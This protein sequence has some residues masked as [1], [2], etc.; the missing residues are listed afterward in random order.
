MSDGFF[1]EL[2]RRNVIRMAGLYLAAG[3]VAIEVAGTVLPML[4]A[5]EWIG[6][7]VL[8]LIAI[9]FVP[10]LVFAWVFEITPDG[11]KR[12]NEIE[13]HTSIMPQT[14]KRMD[15]AI[16]AV[17]LVG[18]VY[19]AFDKFVLA[20][21]REAAVV[22]S[23]VES[24]AKTRP[25]AASAIQTAIPAKSIAVLPLLND[26]GDKEQQYFADGLSENLINALS[27]FD[28]L[29]VIGRNSAFQFREHQE[30]SVAIGRKLGVA[31]LLEG[32]V[33]RQ[34][35]TVRINAQLVKAA[36]GS[37]LWSQRYDRAYI[38]LFALQDEITQA[39]AEALRAG[40]LGFS[41]SR[42]PLHRSKSGELVPGTDA[43]QAELFAIGEVMA[44]VPVVAE[45]AFAAGQRW[46]RAETFLLVDHLCETRSDRLYQT[47][48][49]VPA[50]LL[51]CK[52]EPVIYESTKEI[53]LTELKNFLR[54]VF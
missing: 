34:G 13:R 7:A 5:P 38:D 26:S 43:D 25:L 46:E 48:F 47:A 28:G 24:V 14:G 18:V 1:A 45:E 10:A 20:P 33:R 53:S 31:T 23:A 41:T 12:E 39:V 29:K 40:A 6:R 2:K 27:Q 17:L 11:L 32:S 9:G 16:I 8:A 22:A 35:D 54:C 51:I 49:S 19:L 42:T 52:V 4:D 3:W 21:R 44:G 36:D 37:T 50:C 15:R 30:D